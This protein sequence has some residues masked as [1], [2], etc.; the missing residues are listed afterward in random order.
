MTRAWPQAVAEGGVQFVVAL[1]ADGDDGGGDAGDGADFRGEFADAF[2]AADA[3][4][5]HDAGVHEGAGDGGVGIGPGDDERAEVVAL[6]AFIDAEMGGEH[7]GIV[8][9]LVAEPGFAEDFGFE[10]EADEVLGF[11]ALNEHLGA[12]FVHR[13]VELALAGGVEGVGLLFEIET[14]PCQRLPQQ[15]GLGGGERRGVGGQ[16]HGEMVVSIPA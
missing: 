4:G 12:F 1:G 11:L 6:A 8:Q 7:F 13:D 14:V 2:G 9:F 5:V 16:G 15:A 10:D 3:L